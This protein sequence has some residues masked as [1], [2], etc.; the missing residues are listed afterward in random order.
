MSKEVDAAQVMSFLNALF[1]LFDDLIAQ[2]EVG[3]HQRR[4]V[5][6][7][8][9]RAGRHKVWQAWQAQ[10]AGQGGLAGLGGWAVRP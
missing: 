5:L 8:T 4:T 10:G 1:T 6:G 2:Y 9:I 3:R 7:S